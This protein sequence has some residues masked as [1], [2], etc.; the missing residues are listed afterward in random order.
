SNCRT[1]SSRGELRVRPG[2]WTDRHAF[3]TRRHTRVTFSR[4]RSRYGAGGG[5]S[6]L[7]TREIWVRF[8]CADRALDLSATS[9]E[10]RASFLVR[11]VGRASAPDSMRRLRASRLRH[12][13]EGRC[14]EQSLPRS[15]RDLS[16]DARSLARR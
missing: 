5:D 4:L 16:H 13:K 8:V 2:L 7:L 9:E 14:V 3:G 11:E 12:P 15:G 10:T 6:R 1:G